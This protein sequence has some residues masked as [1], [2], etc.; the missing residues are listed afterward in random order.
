MDLSLFTMYTKCLFIRKIF[1]IMVLYC[2]QRLYLLFGDQKS[3]Q[4]NKYIKKKIEITSI[5]D[6]DVQNSFHFTVIT[7]S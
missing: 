6:S 5:K 1:I 3:M 7:L 4:F 2:Y